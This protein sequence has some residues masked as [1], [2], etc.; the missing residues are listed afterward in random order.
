MRI[1][2]LLAFACF[3]PLATAAQTTA[4]EKSPQ[5]G[6]SAATRKPYGSAKSS[7]K[8]A[9]TAARHRKGSKKKAAQSWRTRQSAPT[10]ERYKEIQ[11]ALAK[12]GYLEEAPSGI[13]DTQSGEALRRF[14]QDQSLEPTGKLNSLSLIALGLGAKHEPVVGPP[15]RPAG[16]PGAAPRNP[17]PEIPAPPQ[18]VPPAGADQLPAPPAL[19]APPPPDAGR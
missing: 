19:P 7:R 11:E 6:K 15:H 10:P 2:A 17:A 3:V 8:R 12:R 14:Q 13:W 16:A 18:L 5:P 1:T 4:H 9:G